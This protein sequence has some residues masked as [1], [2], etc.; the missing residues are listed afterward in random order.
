MHGLL[1]KLVR[2]KQL[3]IIVA[4]IFAHMSFII[5]LDRLIETEHWIAFRH[6][7]PS[8]P[9]HILLVPKQALPNLLAISPSNTELMVE[10]IPTVQKI[11]SD[12]NLDQIG[13]RLIV[14]G[15]AYQDIPQLHFHLISGEAFK[16]RSK[17]L[18]G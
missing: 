16:K 1:I 17:H 3:R 12:H 2:I 6:P 18:A 13:Y 8:Y 9:I 11:V 14:N 15:G 5:P 4:W 10:L 7:Q